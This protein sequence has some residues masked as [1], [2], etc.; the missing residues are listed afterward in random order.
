[1][2]VLL[3]LSPIQRRPR[4]AHLEEVE[5]APLGGL[6]GNLGPGPNG[7]DWGLSCPAINQDVAP[8]LIFP[9]S[10]MRTIVQR[11]LLGV[12][13][14]ATVDET[15]GVWPDAVDE[16][17]APSGTVAAGDVGILGVPVHEHLA[18]G[19]G[20]GVW[21]RRML[22]PYTISRWSIRGVR[23]ILLWSLLAHVRSRRNLTSS[24]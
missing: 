7:L 19:K 17:V 4:E 12:A 21:I 18:Y 24:L 6:R 22:L 1:M 3:Q 20:V 10:S 16:P 23:L 8:H 11:V 2:H 9:V 5:Q 14:R 15:A 13:G